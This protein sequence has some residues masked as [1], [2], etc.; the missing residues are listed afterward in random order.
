[1]NRIKDELKEYFGIEDERQFRINAYGLTGAGIYFI[2]STLKVMVRVNQAPDQFKKLSTDLWRRMAASP[3]EETPLIND[4][5]SWF[6]VKHLDEQH[7]YVQLVKN[8]YSEEYNDAVFKIKFQHMNAKREF[9]VAKLLNLYLFT[10]KMK[11]LPLAYF[12][13]FFLKINGFIG[14]QRG[15]LSSTAY[16]IMLVNYLQMQY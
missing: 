15:W 8:D 9:L 11:F 12:W 1:M 6:V 2:N 10:D 3:N 16:L 13:L 7:I 5:K 4:G 14:K